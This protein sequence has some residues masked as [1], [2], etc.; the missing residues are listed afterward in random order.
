MS[1]PI[2]KKLTNILY[3]RRGEGGEGR[4]GGPLWSLAGLGGD[5]RTSLTT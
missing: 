4:L 3:I 5:T 2:T 1:I